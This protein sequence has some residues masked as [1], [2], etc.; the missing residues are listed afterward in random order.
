MPCKQ[1]QYAA[2][3]THIPPTLLEYIMQKNSYAFLLIASFL[4]SL[5]VA[6][7]ST[8]SFFAL[9]IML[10]V[11]AIA[12]RLIVQPEAPKSLTTAWPF[13]ALVLAISLTQPADMPNFALLLTLCFCTYILR[14]S[15]M[16]WVQVNRFLLT[17]FTSLVMWPAASSFATPYPAAGLFILT[18]LMLLSQ[19]RVANL[20]LAARIALLSATTLIHPVLTLLPALSG[21]TL[22]AVWPK[23]AIAVTVAGTTLTLALYNQFSAHWWE[24]VAESTLHSLI[25][26]PEG[27]AA[28]ALLAIVITQ[29]VYHWRWWT[30]PQQLA[31][32]LTTVFAILI[33][34]ETTEPT[35]LALTFP[36]IT[37]TL[38]RPNYRS[39]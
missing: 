27:F 15:N 16:P 31:W 30:A 14:S 7:E 8:N 35:T 10:L 19:H 36:L 34:S 29:S 38:L 39:K 4:T 5:P 33:L 23:R 17:T 12:L 22:F 37:H 1:P 6:L 11:Q 32:L 24:V 13:T 25:D 9:G 2:N 18:L 20:E 3:P 28:L 21:I 26:G